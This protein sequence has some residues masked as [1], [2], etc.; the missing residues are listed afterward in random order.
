MNQKPLQTQL[1]DVVLSYEKCEEGLDD[2]LITAAHINRI[3]LL[4]DIGNLFQNATE[5]KK[6]VQEVITKL[7]PYSA[8]SMESIESSKPRKMYP[9]FTRT[10]DD[11]MELTGRSKS[12]SGEYHY[13]IS[14]PV[15][16]EV[17]DAMKKIGTAYRQ[18]DVVAALPNTHKYLVNLAQ[19]FLVAKKVVQKVR[20]GVYDAVDW[21]TFRKNAESA[22]NSLSDSP[23]S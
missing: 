17:I 1:A 14:K 8:L 7:K 5:Q 6:K 2:C 18:K 9:V 11:R 19:Q 22:W 21:N 13:R 20:W 3:D 4:S 15:Y 10:S 23:L 16:D 12:V